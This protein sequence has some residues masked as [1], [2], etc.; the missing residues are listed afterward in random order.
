MRPIALFRLLPALLTLAAWGCA[1]I[2]RA[3]YDFQPP[4]T[5]AA[6]AC[7]EQCAATRKGCGRACD[8]QTPNCGNSA[9]YPGTRPLSGEILPPAPVLQSRIGPMGDGDLDCSDLEPVLQSGL[10]CRLA[11]DD[12]YRQCYAKCGGTVIPRQECVAFCR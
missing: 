7:V 3:A 11:C 10:Q 4:A 5:A 2:T 8:L 12:L 6:Q 9:L 1:P